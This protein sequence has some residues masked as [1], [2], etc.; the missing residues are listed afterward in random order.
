[1]GFKVNE[2]RVASFGFNSVSVGRRKEEAEA[3]LKKVKAILKE[4]NEKQR[5]IEKELFLKEHP[6]KKLPW[7]R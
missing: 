6:P 7:E 4:R 2:K 5:F 1:M 3:Q